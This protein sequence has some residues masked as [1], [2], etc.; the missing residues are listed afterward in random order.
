MS[1]FGYIPDP[2]EIGHKKMD[3]L[4]AK[5][6]A[7]KEAADIEASAEYFAAEEEAIKKQKKA[8]R[9]DMIRVLSEK[10]LPEENDPWGDIN[11]S[12]RRR[13]RWEK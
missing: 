12:Q 6:A 1:S 5:A 4:L 7:E 3:K 10:E 8:D 9:D 11:P 13:P 2:L